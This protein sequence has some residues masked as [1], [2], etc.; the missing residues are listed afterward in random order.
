[1]RENKSKRKYLKIDAMNCSLCGRCL[2]ACS[3]QHFGVYTPQKAALRIENFLPDSFKVRIKFC[4]QCSQEYCIKACHKKA[5]TRDISGVVTL[6]RDLC[7]SCNGEFKCVSACKAGL[8]FKQEDVPFPIK[9]DLCGGDPACIKAC[10]LGL[11]SVIEN[12]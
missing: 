6:N 4:I 12:G 1:M 8:I 11:I 9:C 7:D 5:L 3:W 2:M 10:P